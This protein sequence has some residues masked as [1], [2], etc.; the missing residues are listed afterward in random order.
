MWTME[1]MAKRIDWE[2]RKLDR[3]P[4]LSVTDEAEFRKGDAAACWL[5]G[6]EKWEERKQRLAKARKNRGRRSGN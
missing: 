5:A 1:T 3:A 4:R 6:A 2:K